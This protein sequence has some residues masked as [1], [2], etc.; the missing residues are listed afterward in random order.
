[1]VLGLNLL[2]RICS[3]GVF[4]VNRVSAIPGRCS[5]Y[6]APSHLPDAGIGLYAGINISASKIVALSKSILVDSDMVFDMGIN[7]YI[8]TKSD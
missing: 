8:D 6:M 2:V 7:L 5:L 1:M 3:I 4:L